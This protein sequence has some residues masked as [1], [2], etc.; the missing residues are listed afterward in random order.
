MGA[1]IHFFIFAFIKI[2]KPCTGMCKYIGMFFKTNIRDFKS[3][4]SDSIFAEM[5]SFYK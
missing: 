1:L 3:R 2:Y 4:I 5:Q